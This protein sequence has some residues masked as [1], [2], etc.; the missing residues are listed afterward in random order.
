MTEIISLL[1]NS[2]V[3]VSTEVGGGGGA[4]CALRVKAT[5]RAQRDSAV[6]SESGACHLV[7]ADAN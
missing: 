4:C 5:S 7:Y 6:T 1:Q 3:A 2:T